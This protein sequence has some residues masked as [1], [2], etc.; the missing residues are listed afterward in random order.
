MTNYEFYKEEIEMR[1]RNETSF[2]FTK[3]GCIVDC[4]NINCDF[5]PQVSGVWSHNISGYENKL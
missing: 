2:A 4:K 5:N 1:Y 3:N